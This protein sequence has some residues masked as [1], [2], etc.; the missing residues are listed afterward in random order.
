MSALY[1]RG[2]MDVVRTVT[3]QECYIHDKVKKKFLQVENTQRETLNYSPM[4]NGN[5]LL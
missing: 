2:P 1:W 5:R 3:R 4:E